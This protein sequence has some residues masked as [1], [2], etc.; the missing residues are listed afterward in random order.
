MKNH[1]IASLVFFVSAC[2]GPTYYEAAVNDFT[3]AN[4][5]AV[6]QL[7]AST[8]VTIDKSVPVLVATLVNIDALNDTS[9]FGRLISEQVSTRF[10]QQGFNVVEMKIRSDIY[11]REGSGEMMLSRD[12]RDLSKNYKA[13][14]VVVGN[15][16]LASGYVYLTL[17]VVA[18]TDN[19]VISAVNYAL[20][21]TENN[22]VML[23]LQK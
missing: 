16:A 8:T 21:L 17:K 14:V 22:R 13:Q 7:L 10:S 18:L 1:L 15:Y 11:I 20:P 6:E 12:V 4:Y 3:K 23:G 2:A 9:R 19:R 5:A